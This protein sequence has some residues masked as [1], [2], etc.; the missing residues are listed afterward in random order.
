[1]KLLPYTENHHEFRAS[2]KEFIKK[3]IL[4]NNEKWEED[5]IVP[6]EAWIKMGR[7][8]FLCP[9]VEKRYGGMGGDFLYSVIVTEELAYANHNGLYASLHSD[10]IVP[11]IVSYGTEE[12]KQK[13]LP[14]CVTG[15]IITAVAMTEPDAGSDLASIRTIAED[16]G[17]YYVLNGSKTFI[18]NGINCDLVIVA[19]KDP[20]IEDPYNALSLFIVEDGTEGFT[21]GNKLD[22]M[23]MRSQDTAE[24]FFN[25]CKIPKENL[26]GD[27][28]KGFFML[29]E[30]LQ[31][32]RLI[33]AIG[34]L[35]GAEFIYKETLNFC[36]QHTVDGK[37]WVK[38][39]DVQ[40]MLVEL[41]TE[42]KIGRIFL[43]ALIL[44][45]MKGHDVVK[46][47]CMAKYWITDLVKKVA[48]RCLDILGI[49]GI[50]EYTP[51]VRSFRDVRVMSIFA[52]TNEIM[53]KIIGKFSGL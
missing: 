4:P 34:A 11:Y 40:F 16:K 2:L 38:H 47:T 36:R 5:G 12:Q 41:Q 22:K 26:L 14:G 53:K 10:I 6:K 7:A 52:G 37:P 46:E 33:C 44:E 28:N 35:A 50:S 23:G 24:L 51:I 17:E 25:N 1:M 42:I 15:D 31:Q 3:E 27:K 45:H 48:D 8:G 30:K 29:M 13:Y 20:N 39:Q 19:A 21:K 49:I 32:E 18:S 9:T 43:E